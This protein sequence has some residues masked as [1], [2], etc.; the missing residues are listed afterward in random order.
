MFAE[1]LLAWFDQHGRRD[2]PWQHPRSGYRVWLSEIMLQQ[3]Q[4]A[5]VIPYFQ[6]FVARI[7]SVRALAAADTDAVMAL[8][9]GLGYYSRARNL[10]A[11]AK[12]CV[13]QHDGELPNNIAALMALPGIGRSTAA[14]IVSQAFNA[15]AAILDANVKRVLAR[16][17]ATRTALTGKAVEN[18]LLLH[19]EA[20]L[21]SARFADYTQ[22]L[23]DL[24]AL[25]CKSANP[26][27]ARC[28]VSSSCAALA[29]NLV[30]EL[31]V[32]AKKKPVPTRHCI[33]LVVR[34]EAGRTLLQRRPPHGIWGGLFALPE[35][36]P[37]VLNS[38]LNFA[39]LRVNKLL[40]GASL[41]V[42]KHQFTHFTLQ[43]TPVL[44]QAEARSGMQ[45]DSLI[46]ADASTLAGLGLPAPIRT[47]L[48][49]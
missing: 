25:V 10:H 26:H 47:L 3:T 20:C 11:A 18:A 6:R 44:A 9:A 15:P 43:A 1:A 37:D 21:P 27:C 2:L 33:W 8:W 7:D 38:T 41:P 46:W 34:D 13:A 31:P 39:Q 4:V 36:D 12:L 22:A 19:A 29:Q 49:G 24:G 16:Q 23:M 40:I 42:I 45:D 14:A 35:Y 32:K 17:I 28:P 30:S 5:T 48:I